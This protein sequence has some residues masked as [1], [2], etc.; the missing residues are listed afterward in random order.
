M[1]KLL[2]AVTVLAVSTAQADTIFVDD[3]FGN[4]CPGT[5]TV[6]DP[7]CSI[8]DA[9]ADP[10]TVNGD[11]IVVAPGTYF[12]AINFNGKAI[13]VGSSGGA[14]VTTIDGTGNFHVVQCVGGEGPDTVLD[15]FTIT[16]IG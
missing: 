7:F 14:A 3:D 15:G 16:V 13:T 1:K 10:G 2:A 5:G 8:Q 9:I 6:G 12:E 4:P 11:E